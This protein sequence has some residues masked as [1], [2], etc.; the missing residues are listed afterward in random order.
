VPGAPELIE[1]DFS[2]RGY[3]KGVVSTGGTYVSDAFV[4]A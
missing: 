2:G 3:F 4:S 1:K